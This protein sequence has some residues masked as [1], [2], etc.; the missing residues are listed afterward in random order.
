MHFVP[1]FRFSA[2]LVNDNV[3]RSVRRRGNV[4]NGANDGLRYFNAINAPSNANWN[5]GAGHYPSPSLI[6]TLMRHPV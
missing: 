5:Y 6:Q 3:V 1:G 4:N 2:Y